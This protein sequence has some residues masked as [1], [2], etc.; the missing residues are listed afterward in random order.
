[1]VSI[2]LWTAGSFS[3]WICFSSSE[4]CREWVVK[5]HWNNTHM[6]W[7]YGSLHKTAQ[8]EWL[9]TRES[10]MH[11]GKQYPVTRVMIAA[12]QLLFNTFQWAIDDNNGSY[13][14]I[15]KAHASNE[16]TGCIYIHL[17]CK[18]PRPQWICTARCMQL[19]TLGRCRSARTI[20]L[21]QCLHLTLVR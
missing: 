14:F 4:A 17:G 10:S 12:I 16:K 13:T 11:Q 9:G 1:M 2:M 15:P 20:S 19:A 18:W 3:L 5:I 8:V 7:C 21:L 6:S